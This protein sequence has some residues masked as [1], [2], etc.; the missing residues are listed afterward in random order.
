MSW[1]P[2]KFRNELLL[3]DISQL[4]RPR[5]NRP[6]ETGYWRGG[7]SLLLPTLGIEYDPVTQRFK[8]G[9]ISVESDD[10]SGRP[11]T[12]ETLKMLNVFVQQLMKTV[13]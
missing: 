4:L 2:G 11:S 1:T 8:N 6:A 13:D 7:A 5:R 12:V 3:L 9:R 10:R